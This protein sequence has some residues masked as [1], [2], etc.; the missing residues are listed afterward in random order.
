MV[1]VSWYAAMAYA[2][3]AGKR[4]PTE[5]EWEKAARGGREGQ[6]YPWGNTINSSLANYN[7]DVKWT[8]PV[9]NYGANGYRLFDMAGNAGEWCLDAYD[10]GFYARSPR[11]NP[12]SAGKMTLGVLIAN[13]DLTRIPREQHFEIILREVIDNYHNVNVKD[14]R[15]LRGGSWY[16]V[17]QNLRVATRFRVT[18]TA[19]DVSFDFRCARAVTP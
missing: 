4:L 3:W 12:I 5:A 18:P 2:Q 14:S 15:V 10:D 17:A 11:R 7:S 8:T 1:Y 9:G 13:F 19:A 16:N 6:K